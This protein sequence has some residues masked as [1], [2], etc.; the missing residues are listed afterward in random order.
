[1]YNSNKFQGNHG[2]GAVFVFPSGNGGLHGDNCGADG[3]VNHPNV[4][5]VSALS[6][7]GLSPSYSEACAAVSAAVP[8]GG[9]EDKL[10]F[11]QQIIKRHLFVVSNL[12]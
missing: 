1:M 8:V 3:F 9:A 6:E 2:K 11:K 10:T 5:T 7:N 4:I 12:T